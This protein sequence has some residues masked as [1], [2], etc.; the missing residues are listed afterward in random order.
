MVEA[1]FKKVTVGKR[2]FFFFFYEK[3]SCDASISSLLNL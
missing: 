3:E 2:Q 1:L